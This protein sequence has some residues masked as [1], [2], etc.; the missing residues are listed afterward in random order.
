MP[1]SSPATDP[2]VEALDVLIDQSQ[3][4]FAIYDTRRSNA[5]GKA[6]GILTAAAGIAALTV[7]AASLVKHVNVEL[8]VGLVGFLVLSIVC[9]IYAGAAAGLRQRGPLVNPPRSEPDDD[10]A[11]PTDGARQP[12]LSTESAAYAKAALAF[13]ITANEILDECQNDASVAIVVRVRTLQLWRE[14]QADAHH[15]AQ[16]KDRAVGMAGI[17][18]GFALMSGAAMVIVILAHSG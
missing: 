17:T 11:W 4:L 3:R 16:R 10:Q 15:L 14:R 13:N 1:D 7:T 12:L 9:A 8:A 18:L 5:E 2:R 6:A